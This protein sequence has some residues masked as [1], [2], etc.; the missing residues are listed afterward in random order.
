MLQEHCF[1][2][3]ISELRPGPATAFLCCMYCA[4]A[5]CRSGLCSSQGS[6]WP[7]CQQIN[8]TLNNCP[9]IHTSDNCTLAKQSD[10]TSLAACCRSFSSLARSTRHPSASRTTCAPW[11]PQCVTAARSP[12]AAP[13]LM[14]QGTLLAMQAA[15]AVG[16]ML[17]HLQLWLRQMPRPLGMQLVS[18]TG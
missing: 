8:N 12:A 2:F 3:C 13:L 6:Q 17:Q 9:L 15:G 14:S 18:L 11:W 10:N 7:S 5:C 4:L 1:A 16:W